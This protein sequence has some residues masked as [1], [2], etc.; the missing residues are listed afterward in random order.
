[1]KANLYQI[2]L[3]GIVLILC[4]AGCTSGAAQQAPGQAALAS[5]PLAAP[6][7]GA[8]DRLN[9]GDL[10]GSMAFFADEATYHIIGLPTGE[11]NLKGKEAIRGMYEENIGSHFKMLVNVVKI[12]GNTVTTLT[13]TWHDF[14][15]QIGVAPL[16]ATEVYLIKDGK[17]AN[18][19]WTLTPGSQE[20][21]NFAFETAQAPT[22]T[23][24]EAV[25]I[26]VTI[27]GNKCRYDGP[28]TVNP[29][30]LRVAI[31]V[32]DVDK[33][34]YAVTFFNLEAGKTF[35]DL[36][37][38][39]YQ[40]VP[41]DWAHMVGESEA[42]RPGKR[43]TFN[44]SVEK[45][46]VYVICW[47]KP[48]DAAIG[49]LGPIE[50]ESVSATSNNLNS[51]PTASNEPEIL[52]SS[53]D[54][55]MGKWTTYCSVAHERCVLEFRAT[56]NYRLGLIEIP[57]AVMAGN[58]SF[59]N[60][61]IQFETDSGLCDEWPQAIYKVYIVKQDGKP[62]SLHFDVVGSDPCKDRSLTLGSVFSFKQ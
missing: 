59:Q 18:V 61:Q 60:G 10:D 17:I 7:L 58:Y 20:R 38:A 24:T 28:M 29:G 40:P 19:T 32:R 27:E 26:T 21:I 13:T 8:A 55:L 4:V 48:P 46:P 2:T 50:V 5:S 56:N 33:E 34:A 9:A 52:V 47:S 11:E 30:K 39:T 15:R 42:G 37:G 31:D 54:D 1:M 12:E 22:P 35:A 16:E 62:V 53:I 49:G 23:P 45:G 25:D 57:G 36:M 51:S 14:T 44:F 43:N 6:V 41:P 3:I